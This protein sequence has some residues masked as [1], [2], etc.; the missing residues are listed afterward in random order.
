[1]R[2]L[3]HILEI[4]LRSNNVKI[5]L[6]KL[7]L[8]VFPLFLPVIDRNLLKICQFGLIQITMRLEQRKRELSD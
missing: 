7:N 8:K 2:G 5:N 1:M 4:Y 6:N 3:L